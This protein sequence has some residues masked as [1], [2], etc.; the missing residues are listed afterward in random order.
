MAPVISSQ[1]TLK[2]IHREIA[3]VAREDLGS[4]TL[5]P[6]DSLF[7]WKGSIPGPAGS[8]YEKGVFGVDVVL[9]TDYPC[10]YLLPTFFRWL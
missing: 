3:D 8:P 9:G 7:V 2:R 4:I 10:V 1:M 6:T 5:G